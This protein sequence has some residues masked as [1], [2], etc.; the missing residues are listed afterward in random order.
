M[1]AKVVPCDLV[2]DSNAVEDVCGVCHGDGTTC[3]LKQGS[4]VLV[5]TRPESDA[6]GI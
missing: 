1:T 2:L 6:H 5:M 4:K 3:K